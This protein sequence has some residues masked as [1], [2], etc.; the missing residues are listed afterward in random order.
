MRAR[1]HTNSFF[2]VPSLISVAEHTRQRSNATHGLLQTVE[3]RESFSVVR[4]R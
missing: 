4:A 1:R 3:R 2:S